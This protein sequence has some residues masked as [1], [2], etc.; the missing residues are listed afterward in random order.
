MAVIK[1][2]YSGLLASVRKATITKSLF[3]FSAVDCYYLPSEILLRSKSE[4]FL[5]LQLIADKYSSHS[6]SVGAHT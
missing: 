3:I 2:P 4:L 1:S 5:A 6:D